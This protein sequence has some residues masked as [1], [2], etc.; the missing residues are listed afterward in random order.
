MTIRLNGEPYELPGPVT[1]SVLLQSLDL[2]ARRVA[3]ER[4]LVVIKRQEYSTTTVSDRDEIE[5][6]NFVGGG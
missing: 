6:V 2:D 3:V 4:N 5:I 1:L